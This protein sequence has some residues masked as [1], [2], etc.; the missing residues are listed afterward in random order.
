MAGLLEK[1]W[2]MTL[3]SFV[4]AGQLAN[5]F[6]LTS[7]HRRRNARRVRPPDNACCNRHPNQRLLLLTQ[8]PFMCCSMFWM[9]GYQNPSMLCQR[10][11]GSAGD[12]HSLS[13]PCYTTLPENLVTGRFNLVTPL[14]LAALLMCARAY[15]LYN[16]QYCVVQPHSVTSV[17]AVVVALR[18]FRPS[19]LRG[20][21][22][23]YL[24]SG[25]PAS[26]GTLTR[27]DWPV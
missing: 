10:Q 17:R 2:K 21:V 12:W 23:K 20:A 27:T 4:I 3:A 9:T 1:C 22:A 6:M 25:V 16:F 5:C 15:G 19:Q 11:V 8:V 13:I 14:P 18:R 7:A 24:R 26:L